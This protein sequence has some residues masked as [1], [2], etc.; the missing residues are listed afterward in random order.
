MATPYMALTA[1][2]APHMQAVMVNVTGAA[3]T[4]VG[5]VATTPLLAF[6]FELCMTC[7]CACACVQM[8]WQ[9]QAY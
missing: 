3:A 2:K 9:Q 4:N 7:V 5:T 1:A 6:S 8:T